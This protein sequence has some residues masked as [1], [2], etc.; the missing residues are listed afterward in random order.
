MR[1]EGILPAKRIYRGFQQASSGAFGQLGISQE[2]T[3]QKKKPR[4]IS[5]APGL[6]G[7]TSGGRF[8]FEPFSI[9]RGQQGTPD[10]NAG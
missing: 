4:R 1:E 3:S 9:Y 2:G 7:R 8:C 6:A 10:P 5:A